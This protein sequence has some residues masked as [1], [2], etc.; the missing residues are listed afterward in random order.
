MSMME[1]K[2]YHAT[3]DYDPEENVLVGEIFGIRDTIYFE[4]RSLDEFR[5]MFEKSVNDYLKMCEQFGDE[6]D[7]EYK[8]VFNVRISPEKHKQASLLAAEQHISL[9][10]FVSNAIDAALLTC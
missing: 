9:N 8:G 4:G 6:P 5:K 2:G 10:Q 7:K 3:M 1:Y